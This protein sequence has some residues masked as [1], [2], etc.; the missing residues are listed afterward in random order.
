VDMAGPSDLLTLGNQGDSHLVAQTFVHLLGHVP[1]KKLAA[2]LRAASP[3]TYVAPGDPP[4]LLL[5]STDDEI[6]FPQQSN[7]LSWDLGGNGVPHQLLIV[8]GGGH[9][10]NNPGEQPTEAGIT[11]A[12]ADFF[13]RTLVFHQPIT[14]TTTSGSLPP[15][16]TPSGTTGNTGTGNTG[17]TLTGNS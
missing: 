6:V 7:E 12:V 3:V 8:K 14:N 11:R 15:G 5:H 9:E 4:F 13:V 2:D 16:D 17:T 10:F 1:H